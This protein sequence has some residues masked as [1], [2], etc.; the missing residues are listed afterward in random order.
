[1][2]LLRDGRDSLQDRRDGR[3]RRSGR[4]CAAVVPEEANMRA[5]SDVLAISISEKLFN[6]G[7]LVSHD[8]VDLGSSIVDQ[9]AANFLGFTTPHLAVLI[10]GLAS[11]NDNK[12]DGLM[13][14]K[15]ALNADDSDGEEAGLVE[16]SLV[17]T[18]INVDSAVGVGG[19]EEP[20]VTVADGLI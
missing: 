17:G 8:S 19:M 20:E 2:N 15:V 18:T 14:G 3:G 1:M 12:A 4:A 5:M 6:V 11:V 9:D 10:R 7:A 13:R 16:K